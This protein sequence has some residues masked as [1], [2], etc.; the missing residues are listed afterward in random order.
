L[1]DAVVGVIPHYQQQFGIDGVM[2]DMG[3]ALPHSLKQRLIGTARSIN[4]NFA[5]WDENF[6]ISIDSRTE[7]YNAVMGYWLFDV[8]NP[9][10]VYELL[11]SM[12]RSSFPIRFFAAPENH[13]TPRAASRPGG[14]AY[15]RYALTLCAT[16]PGMPFVLTGFELGETQPINTG[17]GFSSEQFALYPPEKLP[18]FSSYAFNWTRP[19]NLVEFIRERLTIRA[20]H[21]TML[22]SDDPGSFT[23]GRADHPSILVYTR[24]KNGDRVSVIANVDT[25]HA[26]HGYAQLPVHAGS[27]AT[28]YGVIGQGRGTGPLVERVVLPV[29]LDPGETL[30][31]PG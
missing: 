30:I 27:S 21:A 31:L 29:K 14:T 2:I 16:V 25:E 1:W 26:H 20:K 28:I 11:R 19:D 6:N 4:P 13:N 9:G 18:L 24:Y 23:M 7:G 5:F 22:N 15:S 8:H 12:A 10:K 3:H 17:L